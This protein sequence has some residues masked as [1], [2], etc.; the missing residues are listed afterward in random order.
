LNNWDY[1]WITKIELFFL[2]Y[3]IN[4]SELTNL[5]RN[6]LMKSSTYVLQNVKKEGLSILPNSNIKDKI[7]N[8]VAQLKN[9]RQKR[10]SNSKKYDLMV[11]EYFNDSLI[12]FR[13][14]YKILNSGSI[15]LWVVGDSALYGVHIQ[16]DILCGEIAELAGFKFIGIEVLRNRRSTRHNV[17]L[18]ESIVK[19]Q[20]I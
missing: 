2:G 20:K 6:K 4:D 12:I 15:C 5:L 16:T 17:K 1:S 11:K 7:E 10:K 14:L 19:L 13:Q 18:Q 8:L 9:E 3:A